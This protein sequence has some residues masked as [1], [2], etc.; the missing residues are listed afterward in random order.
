MMTKDMG[1][2]K[3]Y[4]LEEDAEITGQKESLNSSVRPQHEDGD[5]SLVAGAEKG[6][7]PLPNPEALRKE[8]VPPDHSR[9]PLSPTTESCIPV[10]ESLASSQTLKNPSLTN[11]GGQ[12]SQENMNEHHDITFGYNN[13][14]ETERTNDVMSQHLA[15]DSMVE[16]N[17]TNSLH[18][19]VARQR[20]KRSRKTKAAS[21]S[22]EDVDNDRMPILETA[23]RIK[24]RTELQ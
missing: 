4:S 23:R 9:A 11:F 22:Y 19:E 8:F 21:S 2:D 6:A 16:L 12:E 1:Q 10:T 20:L 7:T 13:M 17:L 3:G 5:D 18:Q 15:N 14:E 24:R